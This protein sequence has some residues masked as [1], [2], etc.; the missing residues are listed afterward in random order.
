M[1]NKMT[2]LNI[3][4]MIIPFV[5]AVSRIQREEVDVV[6]DVSEVSFQA[7]RLTDAR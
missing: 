2:V 5:G 1:Y 3:I 7:D 4:H 6:K